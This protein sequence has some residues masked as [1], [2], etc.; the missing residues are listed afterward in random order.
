MIKKTAFIVAA[1]AFA[2]CGFV[3]AQAKTD[4][5][6]LMTQAKLQ[7]DLGNHRHAAEIF[8]SIVKDRNAPVTLRREAMVR[9][10]LALSAAG[11]PKRTKEVFKEALTSASADPA[12]L[13]FLTYAVVRT[14]PGKIWPGFRATIEDL[15]KTAEVVTLEELAR[16]DSTSKRVFLKKADLELR[17]VWR[18]SHPLERAAYE[19]DKMLGLDMVPPTQ[20]RII[21]GRPG[22]IQLWVNN[23]KPY[24]QF[25]GPAAATSNWSH[26]VARMKVFDALIANP[27]RPALNLL[28]DPDGEIVLVDHELAFTAQT[29]LSSLP[30]RFDRRLVTKLQA[31]RESELQIRLKDLSADEVRSLLKRR[32]ALLA[33]LARLVAEKGEAAVLF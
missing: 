31:L 2:L 18:P 17:A 32:D 14:V 26:Q 28:V 13:R 4:S 1:S 7:A 22:S 8:D 29:E 15:L 21:D 24:T 27:G 33:H 9:L 19:L 11:D 12:A 25:E 16:G 5:A 6:A 10:G 3:A 20:E 30:D 23:C